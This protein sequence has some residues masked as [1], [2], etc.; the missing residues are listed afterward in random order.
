MVIDENA[1]AKGK[2]RSDY[3]PAL[4]D[5]IPA[6][7]YDAVYDRGEGIQW[8]WHYERYAAVVGFLPAVGASILDLGCGPGTFLG[9]YAAA[10]DAGVGV[11]LARPQIEYANSKYR[12]ERL[13]FEAKDAVGFAGEQQFEVVV[14]IEVIEH[15]PI[16]ET[17]T[18]LKTIFDL[19]TPGGTV[20]LATPNYSSLWPIIE[21]FISKKGPVNYLEQ[22]IN[23][24]TVARLEQELTKAGLVVVSRR[25]IFLVSPFLACISTR[26]A[27]WVYRAEQRLVPWLGS[28]IVISARRPVLPDARNLPPRYKP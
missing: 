3:Y 5:G 2:R 16:T 27:R 9:N 12:S 13:R 20:V 28:E 22:H 23:R 6:G 25:T 8:F 1:S 24:F 11:D 21:W 19:L 4:Y 14:S 15:L 18:F 7:Y 26:L 17:Q 10:Y